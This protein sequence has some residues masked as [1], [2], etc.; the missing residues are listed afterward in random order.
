MTL[1]TITSL[2]AAKRHKRN[3]DA[4]LTI[5]DPR[6]RPN[7]RLRFNK[8]PAPDHLVLRFE[9]LD[10]GPGHLTLPTLA[11]AEAI[12]AFG[13]RHSANRLLIHCHAGLSRSTAAGLAI[14]A[15]R[16]GPGN[17]AKALTQLLAIRPQ[18]VPNLWLTAAA[19]DALGRD[20]RL[21]AAVLAEN[22]RR[23]DWQDLRSRK[24]KLLRDQPYRFF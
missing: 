21:T 17:E 12:L 10:E 4:V 5:E 8:R 20:G 3:F 22:E 16:L 11:D 24:A 6:T 1:L 18:A 2:T 19:D 15:D 23:P 14:L 13:R 7:D 9:D